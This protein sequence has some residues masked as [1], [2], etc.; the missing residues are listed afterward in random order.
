MLP[1]SGQ[2]Q[3]QPIVLGSGFCGCGAEAQCRRLS[4]R[5]PYER[6]P[7]LTPHPSPR[8]RLLLTPD[9]RVK[10]LSHMCP[11]RNPEHGVGRGPGGPAPGPSQC[12]GRQLCAGRG[13]GRV[14]CAALSSG[15]SHCCEWV[16]EEARGR[17]SR[18]PTEAGVPPVIPQSR[19]GGGPRRV[20]MPGPVGTHVGNCPWP[21]NLSLELPDS[22]MRSWPRLSKQVFQA[23]QKSHRQALAAGL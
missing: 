21:L 5:C 17:G 8:P 23:A 18:G 22:V 20:G 10:N 19:R 7:W 4:L 15:D 3:A 2:R 6:Q 14:C 11:C 9:A 16:P 13:A 1:G 12:P